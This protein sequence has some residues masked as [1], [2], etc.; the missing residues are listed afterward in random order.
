MR[1]MRGPLKR[2]VLGAR[3]V[4][5]L[6]NPQLLFN[7]SKLYH[8]LWFSK[9]ICFIFRCSIKQKCIETK[10]NVR[11]VNWKAYQGHAQAFPSKPG[12]LLAIFFMN[13]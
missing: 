11:H 4:R 3:V 12:K 5:L 6:G 2:G 8:I 13:T 1:I 7:N 10:P 9:V